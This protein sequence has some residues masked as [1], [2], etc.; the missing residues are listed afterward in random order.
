METGEP[1][2]QD[3]ADDVW[4]IIPHGPFV[5]VD[6]YDGNEWGEGDLGAFNTTG[7]YRS[8]LVDVLI[9]SPVEEIDLAMSLDR[10]RRLLRKHC[11]GW[12]YVLDDVAGQHGKLIWRLVNRRAVCVTCGQPSFGEVYYKGTYLT[13]CGPHMA[14]HNRKVRHLRVNS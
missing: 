8:R 10:A 9:Y 12:G 13:Y 11:E 6:S 3:V 4:R 7:L 1:I 5:A 2:M 14:E